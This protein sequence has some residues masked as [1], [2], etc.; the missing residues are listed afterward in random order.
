MRIDKWLWAVRIYKTRTL[1]AAACRNGQVTIAGQPIKPSREVKID[2]VALARTGDITRTLK[3]RDLPP[4]RIGA[5]VAPQYVEDLTPPEEYQK[6]RERPL[7]PIFYR[8]KGLGRPT[9][10]D[11]REMGKI[12]KLF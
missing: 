6:R 2:D 8:P 9:K 10:K 7:E 11:R 1:A 3:V 12:R 5:P 4:Q